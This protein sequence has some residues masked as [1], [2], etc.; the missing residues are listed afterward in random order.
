MTADRNGIGEFLVARRWPLFAVAAICALTG[1]V[2]VG[3]MELDRSIESL[4]PADD[5]ILA[6]FF[7]LQRRFGGNAIILAAYQD[8]DL[9]SEDGSGILRNEV[10]SERMPALNAL[11]DEH[12][13]R[14]D[15]GAP[16]AIPTR[17]R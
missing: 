15:P 13:I 1:F 5:P 16:I 10:I 11:L 12:G 6:P 2:T 7:R 3:E 17:P 4:F 8:D 14:P 9:L